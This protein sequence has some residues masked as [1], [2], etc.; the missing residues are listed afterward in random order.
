MKRRTRSLS[1][2]FLQWLYTDGQD[3]LDEITVRR[4]RHRVDLVFRRF[5]ETL[6]GTVHHNMISV[7]AM[8]GKVCWDFVYDADVSPERTSAGWVCTQCPEPQLFESRYNLLREHL[9]SPF[10]EWVFGPLAANRSVEFWDFSGMTMAKLRPEPELSP[11]I[12]RAHERH[13]SGRAKLERSK[14]S[15]EELHAYDRL[16]MAEI[17]QLWREDAL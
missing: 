5:R 6:S 2:C 1:N 3:L 12:V 7:A 4:R 9:F 11:S 10:R 8:K 15:R 16:M 17:D 14:A 13:T